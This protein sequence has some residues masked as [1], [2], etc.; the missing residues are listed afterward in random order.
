MILFD[1]FFIP[2]ALRIIPKSYSSADLNA[3]L[4]RYSPSSA[5]NEAAGTGTYRQLAEKVKHITDITMPLYI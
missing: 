1:L 3:G 2:T 5:E 4:K